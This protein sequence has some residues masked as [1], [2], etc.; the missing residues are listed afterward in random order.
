MKSSTNKNKR[1]K[2]LLFLNTQNTIVFLHFFFK[3]YMSWVNDS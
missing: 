3:I 1:Y 2:R